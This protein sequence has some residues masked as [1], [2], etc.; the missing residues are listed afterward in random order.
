MFMKVYVFA[1]NCNTNGSLET[2]LAE[3]MREKLQVFHLYLMRPQDDQ[4]RLCTNLVGTEEAPGKS[5]CKSFKAKLENIRK[6][7][8]KITSIHFSMIFH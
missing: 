5:V 2:H 6:R 3:K 7:L 1:H 4:K 8:G